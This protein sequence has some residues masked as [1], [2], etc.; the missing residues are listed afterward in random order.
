[1][2][3][4]I[5]SLSI[6]EQKLVIEP[7]NDTSHIMYQ[8]IQAFK[9]S[10]KVWECEIGQKKE[11]RSL[12]ANSYAWTL[13]TK[14]ADVLRTSKEEE[15]LKALKKY[16]QSQVVSVIKDGVELLKRSVKYCEEFGESTLNGKEFVH[17]KVY[18]GSSEFDKREM[19]IFIDGIISDCKELDI[20][21]MTPN[22]I[23]RL[24]NAWG[25][26]K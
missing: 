19:A 21:T 14:I 20:E 11:K 25:N 6:Q 18:T 4:Y 8:L 17:I 13:L 15:Y 22:E 1:M 3:L 10:K 23:E 2:K 5:K 9:G 24:K 26:V 12:N 16:G 7:T